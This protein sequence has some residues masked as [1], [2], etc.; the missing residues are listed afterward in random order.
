MVYGEADEHFV[1]NIIKVAK[2]CGK[3]LPRVDNVYIRSQYTYAGNVAW[4][5]IKAKDRLAIDESIGGEYFFITDDTK[6]NDP[7]DFI[8]PYLN[9]QGL[10]I[11]EKSVPFW[12]LYIILSIFFF[13]VET[14]KPF[15]HIKVPEKYNLRKIQYLTNSYFFNREKA[16]LRLG[17]EP[18]YDPDEAERLSLEFYSKLKIDHN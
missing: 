6:I 13:F 18:L 4:A 10:K 3:C 17:Y 2:E 12:L 5:C 15:Y 8:E 1:T 14:I 7:F 11:S 9:S 16:T